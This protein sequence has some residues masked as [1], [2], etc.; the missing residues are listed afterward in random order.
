VPFVTKSFPSAGY[1]DS[2][3]A[4]PLPWSDGRSD[5]CSPKR[6][7]D[8]RSSRSLPTYTCRISTACLF[9]AR[10]RAEAR[11]S[12]NYDRYIGTSTSSDRPWPTTSAQAEVDMRRRQGAA[13]CRRSWPVHLLAM[14][15]PATRASPPSGAPTSACRALLAD[16]RTWKDRV[17]IARIDIHSIKVSV[18]FGGITRRWPRTGTTNNI[19]LSG[20]RR[21]LAIVGCGEAFFFCYP[22]PMPGALPP[23]V[24]PRDRQESRDISRLI[25]D[26]HSTALFGLYASRSSPCRASTSR[27]DSPQGGQPA[28]QRTALGGAGRD[29]LRPMPAC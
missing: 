1:L 28:A 16:I 4:H 5:T 3:A 29:S 27:L 24:S 8:A 17:E 21:T 10:E 22:A 6:E 2:R 19:L 13:P 26:L 20:S 9:A 25:Y 7:V 12:W 18:P 14:A 23:T 11:Y 15:P